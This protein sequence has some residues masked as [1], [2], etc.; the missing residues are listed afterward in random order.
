MNA[1]Y[2]GML[3]SEMAEDPGMMGEFLVYMV[4]QRLPKPKRVQY[5]YRFMRGGEALAEADLLLLVPGGVFVIEVK[6]RLKQTCETSKHNM[7]RVRLLRDMLGLRKKEVPVYSLV[8]FFNEREDKLVWR[9]NAAYLTHYRYLQQTLAWLASLHPHALGREEIAA[10][11]EK[12]QLMK[13]WNTKPPKLKAKAKQQPDTNPTQTTKKDGMTMVHRIL[14]GRKEGF[15]AEAQA[16]LAQ[17]RG[18]LHVE[19]LKSVEVFNRYDVEGADK[20]LLARC[21]PLVFSEPQTDVVVQVLP[22]SDVRFA[23]EYLPG[24]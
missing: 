17:W 20:T 7:E 11:D 21:L 4:L 15:D 9:Q 18:Q 5:G 23:V 3:G 8:V 12:L 14:I 19:G 6:S 2:A 16:L 22:Q 1:E 10:L 24:Q 13:N